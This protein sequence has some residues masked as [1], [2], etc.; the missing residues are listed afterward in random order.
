M[1]ASILEAIGIS[2]A[3]KVSGPAF[4]GTKS[5]RVWFLH[6]DRGMWFF[7]W[8]TEDHKNGAVEGPFDTIDD[9]RDARDARFRSTKN[10]LWV[11]QR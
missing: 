6:S 3:S 7:S 8:R 1:F 5:T 10:V 9:A 4:A 2:P 11:E